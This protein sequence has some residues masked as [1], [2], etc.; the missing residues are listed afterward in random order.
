MPSLGLNE[1]Q[2]QDFFEKYLAGRQEITTDTVSDGIVDSW[3]VPLS[4]PD[5]TYFEGLMQGFGYIMQ[6]VFGFSDGISTSNDNNNQTQ[7]VRRSYSE[8]TGK[9]SHKVNDL[10]TLSTREDPSQ[11][12][13]ER[14]PWDRAIISQ[15]RNYQ[16]PYWDPQTE[17]IYVRGK[18]V[19][20]GQGS[21][22]Y[23]IDSGLDLTHPEFVPS[24]A[25]VRGSTDPNDY[26][27]QWLFADHD[28]REV[29]YDQNN[30]WRR[31][32]YTTSWLDPNDPNGPRFRMD[33][34][35]PILM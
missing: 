12:E 18:A 3:A 8:T 27:V 11:W 28:P 31:V 35:K 24:R 15:P 21:R 6:E 10:K 29:F 13:S 14:R 9:E 23:I 19:A 7:P 22:V 16:V 32:T 30:P 25:R 1:A 33:F 20:P 26:N 2:K 34:C 5:A 17:Y 4:D